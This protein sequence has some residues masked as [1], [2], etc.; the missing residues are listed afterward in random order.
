MSLPIIYKRMKLYTNRPQ[1][2]TILEIKYTDKDKGEKLYREMRGLHVDYI[3]APIEL[4]EDKEFLKYARVSTCMQG[5]EFG[6]VLYYE[7]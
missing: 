1:G 5:Q 2:G 3:I 6:K 4:K 7:E